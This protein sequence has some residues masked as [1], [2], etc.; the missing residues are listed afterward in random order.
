[1]PAELSRHQ[2]QLNFSYPVDPSR[3]PPLAS[4]QTMAWEGGGLVP[5]RVP[6][7]AMFSGTLEPQSLVSP[8]NGQ[9]DV[10]ILINAPFRAL[11][12]HAVSFPLSYS[13]TRY[14]SFM[15]FSLP[16]VWP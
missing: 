4:S 10:P 7:L 3:F 1:M 9:S 11:E 2:S 8:D 16:F 12:G 13:E 5:K 14:T 15:T 6:L